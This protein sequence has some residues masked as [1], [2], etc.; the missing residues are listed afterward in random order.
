M[1]I[2]NLPSG[3]PGARIDSGFAVHSAGIPSRPQRR[4]LSRALGVEGRSLPFG[5]RLLLRVGLGVSAFL[6][7][8]TLRSCPLLETDLQRQLAQFDPG[9]GEGEPG[10]ATEL[11]LV[12]GEMAHE[13][14][15]AGNH[16]FRDPS[17][18]ELLVDKDPIRGL[19]SR[20]HR[21]GAR[22]V[23]VYGVQQVEL[24]VYAEGIDVVLPDDASQRGAIFLEESRFHRLDAPSVP[25]TGQA[26][27]RIRVP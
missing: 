18:G 13:W 11:S 5:I 24:I 26:R 23:Y 1:P 27:L 25:D 15:E 20:L 6:L 12:R 7:L 9:P 10:A 8:L 22:E 19:V 21:I 17:S 16:Q 4:T 3:A 2:A 14:I